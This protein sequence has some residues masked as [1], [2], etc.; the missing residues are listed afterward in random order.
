MIWIFCWAA[1]VAVF[2]L[3]AAMAAWGA[4]AALT[5]AD[6]GGGALLLAAVMALYCA[7]SAHLGLHLAERMLRRYRLRFGARLRAERVANQR[8]G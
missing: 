4:V 6:G 2:F 5:V 1:L 7:G 8:E 3:A